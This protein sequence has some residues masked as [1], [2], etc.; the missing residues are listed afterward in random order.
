MASNTNVSSKHVKAFQQLIEERGEDFLEEVDAWL[1]DHEV[2]PNA[3]NPGRPVSLG[4]GVY[5]FQHDRR[6][7]RAS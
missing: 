1:S 3:S 6:Q 4:V 2:K 5:L 7:G